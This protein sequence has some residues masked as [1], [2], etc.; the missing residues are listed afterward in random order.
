[1]SDRDKVKIQS[2]D[3]RHDKT[4]KCRDK[5]KTE[6][7]KTMSQ[8]SLETRHVSRDPITAVTICIA[9]S[10]CTGSVKYKWKCLFT[11]V[12]SL[13]EPGG[14]VGLVFVGLERT[15]NTTN[16]KRTSWNHRPSRHWFIPF[17]FYRAM[18]YNIAIVIVP[19]CLSVCLLRS[20]S[21]NKHVKLMFLEHNICI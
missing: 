4:Y 8:C 15:P 5:A 2:W 12:I 11:S 20:C 13:A 3:M 6:T 19:V 10:I 18:H 9:Y 21:M 17:Y 14:F 16:S 1:M 7:W